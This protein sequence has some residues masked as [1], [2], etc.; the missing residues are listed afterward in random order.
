M[1]NPV[2]ENGTI[3]EE[4]LAPKVKNVPVAHLEGKK[5]VTRKKKAAQVIN[6]D[7]DDEIKATLTKNNVIKHSA[8]STNVDKKELERKVQAAL[9]DHSSYRS[10][11]PTMSITYDDVLLESNKGMFSKVI[12]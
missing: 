10:P 4:I 1:A 11:S 8:N 9:K 7:N 12:P 3:D 5:K 2:L 6:F